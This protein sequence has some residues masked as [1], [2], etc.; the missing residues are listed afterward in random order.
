MKFSV[1]LF[2]HRTLHCKLMVFCTDL[3]RGL[4]LD[5]LT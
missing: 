1:R 2:T 4:S 5:L 3:G